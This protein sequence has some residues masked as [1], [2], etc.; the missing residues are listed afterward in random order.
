MLDDNSR[1]GLELVAEGCEQFA[2][3][4]DEMAALVREGAEVDR[5]ALA[6]L[7][8]TLATSMRG[9]GTLVRM[10]LAEDRGDKA[11]V[12]SQGIGFLLSEGFR[13]VLSQDKP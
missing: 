6:Y 13:E 7:L 5:Q 10:A 11:A 4:L 12:A 9:S 3:D 2:P 1:K 8:A